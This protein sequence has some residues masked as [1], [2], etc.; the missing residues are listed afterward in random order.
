MTNYLLNRNPISQEMSAKSRYTELHQIKV[1]AY[2][3]KELPESRDNKQN[4]RKSST[5]VQ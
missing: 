1:S 5:D 3:K 2:Q 4:G